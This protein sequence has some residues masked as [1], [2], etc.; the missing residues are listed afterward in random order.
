MLLATAAVSAKSVPVTEQAAS[1]RE[2]FRIVWRRLDP[3]R[4]R[5]ALAVVALVVL[6]GVAELVSIGAVIPFL[7]F[8]AGLQSSTLPPWLDSW[9]ARS[10]LD[11]VQLA[12]AATLFLGAAALV[13]GMVR[14]LFV[15]K[16]QKF[17]FG[18]SYDLGVQVYDTTLRQP[19]PAHVARNSA[20]VLADLNKAQILAGGLFMPIVQAIGSAVIALFVIS[21]LLLID[22]GVALSAGIGFA[23]VYSMVVLG[24]R[25][26]MSRNSVTVA[27]AWGARL[28]AANEGLG[29]IRDIILDQT[30]EAFVDRFR[31]VEKDLASAQLMNY[32]LAA[33]PR[34][35]VE[36]L[37]ILL[38]AG[39]ALALTLR[40]GGLIESLPVLGAMAL[41]AQRLLPLIQNVYA[42]WAAMTTGRE[43]LNDLVRTLSLEAGQEDAMDEAGAGP[44]AGNIVALADVGFRYPGASTAA[45]RDVNLAISKGERIGII[46]RSGSG[47]STLMDLL[48]GLQ[49][50]TEGRMIVD[51]TVID[52]RN[53]NAWRRNVGHVP[54]AIFLADATIAENI[55]FGTPREAIDWPRLEDATRRSQL[56]EFVNKLAEGLHTVVGERGAK[57]SGGQR[58]RIGIARALYKNAK[59][60]IL[61]EATNALDTA[62]EEAVNAAIRA[63][64]RDLTIVVISHRLSS[65]AVCERW[66]SIE[67][68]LVTEVDRAAMARRIAGGL[69]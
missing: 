66:L 59:L 48:L 2:M 20:E 37:G 47:K 16:S 64:D 49:L 41:G 43:M 58:Q 42:G 21:G 50:P 53:L 12:I 25:A 23:L 46:G 31:T 17:V 38:F 19:Y 54:Q 63:L 65:L 26:V 15:W 3:G 44:L 24:T 36:A 28:K 22:A 45:L 57:L 10:G 55:A 8:L 40:S 29:G 27:R 7:T 30:H 13:A 52:H 67:K 35:V 11:A 14:L 51:G 6:S 5:S 1:F 68:G 61:D 32:F 9:I 56:A 62:T 39:I 18:A 60:L 33:A 69:E 34:F 4:R